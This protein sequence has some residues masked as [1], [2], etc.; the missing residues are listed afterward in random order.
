MAQAA[1]R[2]L[3]ARARHLGALCGV[4]AVALATTALAAPA[5][6]KN[7]SW[8]QLTLQQREILAPLAGEW[9]KIE[10][11]R[12]RKWLGVAKRYPKMTPIGKKRVQTRMRTWAELTPAQRKEARK[13]Y[14]RID[15]LPPAKRE[16]L[17]QNWKEY[18]S[19][20]PQQRK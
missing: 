20:P 14:Q 4:L 19:L 8:S 16:A 3:S 5:Q 1:R 18:E 17:R 13:K 12:K 6:N 7:P 2:A 11:V 10:P 9:D 15:K